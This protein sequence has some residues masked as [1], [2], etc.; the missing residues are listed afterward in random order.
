MAT[1]KVLKDCH[2]KKNDKNF[3]KNE[4][5]EATIKEINEFETRLEKAGFETP[6]FERTDN[7]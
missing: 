2:N 5:I 7:K 1:F 6:F 3:K 4:K